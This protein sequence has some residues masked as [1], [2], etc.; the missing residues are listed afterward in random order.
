VF[1]VVHEFGNT[2]TVHLICR[3]WT[4]QGFQELRLE[5]IW[6]QPPLIMFRTEYH[7]YPI[8]DGG[9]HLIWLG[10]DNRER[11]DQLIG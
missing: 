11:L 6:F 3:I 9:D 4:Q 8:M 7:R 10:G 2:I 5:A 1:G